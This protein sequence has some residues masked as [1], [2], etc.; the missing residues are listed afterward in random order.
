MIRMGKR[1]IT[2]FKRPDKELIERFRGKASANVSDCTGRLFAMDSRIR[3]MGKGKSLVGPAFTVNAAMADNLLFHKALLLAKPGDVLVVNAAG[4][5]NYSVCG[6]I[7]FQIAR[8]AGI[9]GIV[10]DGCIRDVEFLEQNDFPVYAIGVTP[11]GP[12]KNGP[13]EINVDICCGGQVVH[14]GDLIVG[15]ADGITVVYPD[16]MAAVADE[17]EKVIAKEAAFEDMIERGRWAEES[18]LA[19]QVEETLTKQGYFILDPE[20]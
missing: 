1:I 15:D 20:A 16:D 8:K 14:P 7:M 5:R 4:D 2:D 6:D 13:G 18:P 17:V 10:I 19:R 11:R 9:A 3:P 12:Y